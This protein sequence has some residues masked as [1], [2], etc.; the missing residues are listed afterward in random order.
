LPRA[1]A[2]KQMATEELRAWAQAHHGRGGRSNGV[3]RVR[4]TGGC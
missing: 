4:I 2:C 3:K 1:A